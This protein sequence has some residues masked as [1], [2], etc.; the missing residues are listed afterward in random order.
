MQAIGAQQGD[1]I[2]PRN[3]GMDPHLRSPSPLSNQVPDFILD[4]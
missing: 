3:R 2:A 1:G 4:K